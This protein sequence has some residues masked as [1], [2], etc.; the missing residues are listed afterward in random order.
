MLLLFASLPLH[1]FFVV[2]LMSSNA[3]LGADWYAQLRLSWVGD[4]L[5]DQQLG[6]GIAWGFGEIPSILVLG[7]VFL[8]W[9]RS[10]EREARHAD[11]RADAGDT[12]KLDAYN[13]YL[14]HLAEHDAKPS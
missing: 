8:Q 12:S 3:V 4:R 2:V 10:D 14:A 11:R 9:I 1:A 13:A 7:V 5:T 6:G